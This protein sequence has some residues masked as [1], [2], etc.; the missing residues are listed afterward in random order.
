VLVREMGMSEA[1]RE[2]IAS[3]GIW[4]SWACAVCMWSS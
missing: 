2:T 3:Q 4:E 1:L